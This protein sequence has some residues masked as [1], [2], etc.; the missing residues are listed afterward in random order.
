M[1]KLV[2][3]HG[4]G[5]LKPLLL[6]GQALTDE[7]K[8]AAGLKKVNVSSREAGD[9]IMLGIGGFTPLTGFMTHADWQGVCDG[10]K[11]ASGLFWPIPITLS[12]D[13][14]IADGLKEGEEI[15]LFD[16]E[17]SEILATMKIAEKYTIDKAH[18]CMQ[19]YKTTDLEHPGVKMVMAQGDVNLAGPVK[20]LSQGGFKEEYGEQFMTPAETRAAFEKMGWSRIAAF[21]TRNP[22]HRSHEY[23]AKIAIETMDGV[24][25]HS[26][27]GALKPGDIPAEVRSEAISV[28]I[29]NYFAPN[30]VIQAGYPLDMRYAGPREALLHALFRQNYGCSHL[31]VGRDHAGVGDYYGPFDAQQ[32]FDEI[33]KDAL[34]TKNLNIDWTFWCNKCGGMASQRT[35]PHTKDDR[36]L[37]SGTKVRAMLSEGQDLPP[38]FS[39]PEVAKVLQK[40]YAGLTAEQ[41]VKV[42]LKGH[43]A[44]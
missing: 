10:M 27:L 33:P 30:T 22:M 40:Y 35:C 29:D 8:R 21:Q 14:A 41:N 3:P 43:S 23:L 26:L 4:G 1:S 34:E 19:V 42:E 11:M 17:R 25:I 28:L 44:V 39:R 38:T 18:E 32:I 6:E 9:L 37:L 7:Q 36:V 13:Q 2:R 24:L 31:I 12:T 5:E 20:V 15:A 16:P